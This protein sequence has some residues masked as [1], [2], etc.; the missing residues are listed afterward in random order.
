VGGFPGSQDIE[1]LIVIYFKVIFLIRF[2]T[3][4]ILPLFFVIGYFQ[5]A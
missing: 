1:D 4:F 3:W 5:E 2:L